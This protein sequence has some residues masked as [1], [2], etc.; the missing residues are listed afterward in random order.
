MQ[1]IGSHIGALYEVKL[2][3]DLLT[4]LLSYLLIEH[5]EHSKPLLNTFLFV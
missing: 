2:Q 4:Y 3:C 1:H 5:F